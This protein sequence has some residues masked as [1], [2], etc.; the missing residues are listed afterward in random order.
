MIRVEID[1]ET[2]VVATFDGQAW[3][4]FQRGDVLRIQRAPVPASILSA[5]GR[6]YFEMLRTKLRWGDS[7]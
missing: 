4:D 3:Y 6:S 1:S 5:P 7:E 2:P